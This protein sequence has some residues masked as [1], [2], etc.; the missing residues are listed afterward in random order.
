MNCILKKVVLVVVAVISTTVASAQ[1]TQEVVYLKNGSIVRG[2]IIEQT[3]NE[4]LKIQTADG[5]IFAYKMDEVQKITKEKPTAHNIISNGTNR[6]VQPGYRGFVDLGYTLGTGELGV[7][8]IE[9]STSHGYQI[10]PY[11]FVG[12]GAGFNYFCS[13]GADAFGIPVFAHVRS[14]FLKNAVSPFFDFKIGYSFLDT[15]GL[16][17]SP[18]VGCHFQVSNT[19][20]LNV[21]IGYTFQNISYEYSYENSYEYYWDSGSENCGG[22]SFKFG[23]DF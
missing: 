22:I 13:D 15:D 11:I 8:R 6:Y 10:N 3:P 14:E 16:Y 17:F 4:S 9:F 21:S 5:S 7:D 12:A 2:V 23:V 1:A 19:I 18:A 20:G